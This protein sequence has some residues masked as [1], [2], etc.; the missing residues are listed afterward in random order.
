MVGV[1]TIQPIVSERTMVKAGTLPKAV[2]R[3]GRIALASAKQCGRS[4]LPGIR[5]PAGYAEWLHRDSD[6]ETFILL[7]PSVGPKA[8]KVRDLLQRPVPQTASLI[9]G[10]E[11]GW[12]S[13]ECDL[14][15]ERGCVAL[16]LGR[17]TLRADAVPLAASAIL[18]S[19]WDER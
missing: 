10:P 4:T 14:A 7:E 5:E 12:T 13:A 6:G 11:G 19:I 16:S 17:L 3:W 15:L 1:H 9:V 18:L 2:E 8:L